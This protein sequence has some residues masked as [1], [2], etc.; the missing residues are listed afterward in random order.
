M[1]LK[2]NLSSRSDFPENRRCVESGG[3]LGNVST[4]LQGLLIITENGRVYCAVPT[5]FLIA[6]HVNRTLSIVIRITVF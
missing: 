5:E 3:R 6:T 2:I 4:P 1:F